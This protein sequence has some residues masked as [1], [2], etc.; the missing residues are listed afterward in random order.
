MNK[1]IIKALLNMGSAEQSNPTK[2]LLPKIKRVIQA[3]KQIGVA[4]SNKRQKWNIQKK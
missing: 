3:I 2:P 4:E 1:E